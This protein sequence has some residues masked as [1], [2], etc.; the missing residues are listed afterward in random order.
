LNATYPVSDLSAA[1]LAPDGSF[2]VIAGGKVLHLR[3]DGTDTGIAVPS[4]G[5]PA[6]RAWAKNGRLIVSDNGL[7]QQVCSS[8]FQVSRS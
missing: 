1:L 4:I 2:W 6:S 3:K 7:R 8:M 5:K